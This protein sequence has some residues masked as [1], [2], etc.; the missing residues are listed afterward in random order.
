VN[1]I[2]P[3]QSRFVSTVSVPTTVVASNFSNW[4]ESK[5][6]DIERA[7]RILKSKFLCLKHPI[8]MHHRDDVF[9]VV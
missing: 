7:F 6:K 3:W 4:Q 5:H 9:Y 1:G 8:L 2:Y